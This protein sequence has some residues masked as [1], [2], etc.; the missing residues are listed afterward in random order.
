MKTVATFTTPLAALPSL[1]LVNADGTEWTDNKQWNLLLDDGG[2]T[3]KFGPIRGT[4]FI[5]R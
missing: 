2:T 4:C 1:T 3:L 5:V